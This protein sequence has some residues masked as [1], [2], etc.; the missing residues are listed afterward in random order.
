MGLNLAKRRLQ[1][2]C[3]FLQARKRFFQPFLDSWSDQYH[4]SYFCTN[5][6]LQR[7]QK[8]AEHLQAL[9]YNKNI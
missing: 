8:L 5:L 3:K 4:P 7:L 6:G 2:L 1:N 9:F